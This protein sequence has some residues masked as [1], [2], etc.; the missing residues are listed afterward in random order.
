MQPAIDRNTLEG[1]IA[2]GRQR[3]RLT[4]QDLQAALP[5]ESMSV[6]DVALIV[7]ELEEA[8]VPVDLEDSLLAPRQHVQVPSG[9]GAVILPFPKRP[10]SRPKPAQD[11]APVGNEQ[12][13]EEDGPS[14]R[15]GVSGAHW[16][17]IGSIV[18]LALVAALV[19]VLRA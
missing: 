8:G 19:W 2:L 3:G 12:A 10:G 17:V 9:P 14:L 5:T 1:L 18:A 6:E 4:N 11:L 7:V 15:S 16:A 13:A